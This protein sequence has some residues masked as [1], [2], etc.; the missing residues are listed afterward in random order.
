MVQKTYSFYNINELKDTL[1][2]ICKD[3]DYNSSSGILIQ[4]YNPR[5]DI[6]E[7]LMIET[8]KETCPKACITGITAANIAGEEFD[9][10]SSFVELS[11]SFFK[12]TTLIQYD[13]DM[14]LTTSF[15]AGRVLN[16][17][18]SSLDNLKCLQIF[19]ASNNLS[20]NAFRYEFRHL[21]LPIFGVKAG[22][23][24]TRQNTAHVYGQNVYSNGF[25]VVAF[26]SQ[27]LRL[28][29]DNNLG[30]QAIGV[31]MTITK[32]TGVNIINE[33][34][35]RP[36][37]EIYS[38]YLKVS[39]NK[40]FVENVCE[41][42]LI[43]ERR[44]IQIARVPAAYQQ[45]GSIV[46]TSDVLVGDHFRL[47]YATKDNLY[48]QSKESATDME[49]FSPQAVYLFECGNR[50]RFLNVDYRRELELYKKNN[51]NLSF[52]TGYAELFITPNGCGGDLNSTL[53]AVGL[54]ESDEGE[55]VIIESRYTP[56][57]YE[58]DVDTDANK[59]IPFVERIL[60]FLESTSK[61]LD[62]MNK[63]LGEIAYID[64]L[65]KIFN[66]WELEKKID[67][68]L[69]LSRQGKSYGLLFFDIDHF[70][71]I[72]DNFGHD[73]GDRA[74]LAVVDI[75][76]TNLKEGHAFG[77]WGGEEFI[78]LYPTDTKDD[79]INFAE[80]IRKTVDETCFVAI[81]HLTIS[82]GTTM[83]K[84]DDTMDSFIKR[85]DNAVYQAKETGRNKVVFI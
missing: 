61:E 20:I 60:A 84:A 23:S 19:Y 76:K 45:D 48:A 3:Q 4:V 14:D 27:K 81:Q 11:V 28:Y 67:E 79:L 64:Q 77:R 65:T 59:E 17:A 49:N 13:F 25:V 7:G 15:N 33:I 26:A 69:E 39:P 9:I 40:Y 38:K 63:E 50:H 46:L 54:K 78:Y 52:V 62:S 72:N 2:T 24:I 66:R 34:D 29:M 1:Q 41:F 30:W 6:D 73:M 58:E 85:A 55:D 10:S 82:V 16:E 8:I 44:G 51:E 68:C 75:I 32:T 36:A 70:K 37:T 18:L 31:N 83:A 56:K 42:P 71:R 74:L 53:V 80:S 12:D 43:L 57:Y 47:S 21:K 35:K 22:R 5:L